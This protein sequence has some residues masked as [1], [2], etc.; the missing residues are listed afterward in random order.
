M[1]RNFLAEEDG[2]GTV[3]LL[4]IIAALVAVALIFKG[5]ISEFVTTASGTV[6]K[7]ASDG[8]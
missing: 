4:L 6:F 8:L 2:L 3:E 5:K 7:K 1:I